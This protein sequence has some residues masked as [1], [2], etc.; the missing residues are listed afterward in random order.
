MPRRGRDERTLQMMEHYVEHWKNGMTPRMI[1][2][3]YGLSYSQIY[4]CLGEIAEKSGYQRKELLEQPHSEYHTSGIR[5]VKGD[6]EKVDAARF[7]AQ[8]EIVGREI[9]TLQTVVN[10]TIKQGKDFEVAYMEA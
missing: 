8:L 2:E 10:D 3:K 4:N 9:N 5:I 1:A 7:E 6:V